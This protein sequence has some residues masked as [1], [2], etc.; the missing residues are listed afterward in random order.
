MHPRELSPYME[1]TAITHRKDMIYLSFISQVTPSESSVIKKVGYDLM[2]L[3]YLKKDVG[4]KSVSRVVMHETLTN[5]RK[6]LIIQMKKPS[7][8]EAWR[9]LFSAAAFH[10]GGKDRDRVDE[11]INPRHGLRAWAISYRA[12]LKDVE[13]LR[14]R[15]DTPFQY[16]K[17]STEEWVQ[18]ETGQRQRH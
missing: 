2:F 6:V 15:K 5:L 4:I 3:R 8:A 18:F 16:F 9:A 14:G 1:V 12:C 13:I 11:D 17:G 7:E 10:Q